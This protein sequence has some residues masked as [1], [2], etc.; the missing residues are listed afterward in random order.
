[1]SSQAEDE[2]FIE[3]TVRQLDHSIRELAVREQKLTSGLYPDRVAELRELWNK[4][5]SRQDEEELRRTLDWNDREL[6]WIWSRQ[7]RAC[8]ARANAGQTLM[9]HYSIDSN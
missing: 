9:R 8:S 3:L 5:L 6:M 2:Q 7:R 4:S 1:M